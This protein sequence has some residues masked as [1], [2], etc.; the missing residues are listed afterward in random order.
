MFQFSGA[1]I[2]PAWEGKNY[3]VMLP[4]IMVFFFIR[5]RLTMPTNGQTSYS[6]SLAGR[7][8]PTDQSL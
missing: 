6:T 8:A 5:S 2:A 1:Q 3:L 4:L 7:N